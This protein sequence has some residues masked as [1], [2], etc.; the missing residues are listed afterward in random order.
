M[1]PN[2]AFAHACLVADVEVDDETGEVTVLGMNS[3][4][5]LAASSTPAW[6]SSSWS[7]GRGWA[8]PM[9]CMKRRSPYYPNPDHGPRD[10]NE[11]LMPGP[12]DLAPY[13]ITI[14]ERPAPDGR[15]AARGRGKCAPTLCCRPS[16]N[17]V[18][19]AVGVRVNDLPITPEK[20]LRGIKAN[21]GARHNR[22]AVERSES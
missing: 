22:V 20:I 14:L 9:P 16:P 4:Y 11:Y 13:S 19:N 10:F 12:G 17:A 18:Y 1:N 6:W 2:T 21:G 3:A 15:S 7:A 8:F 5:E